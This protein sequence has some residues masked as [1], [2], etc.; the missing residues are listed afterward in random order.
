MNKFQ[1]F[2]IVRL[3]NCNEDFLVVLE[4]DTVLLKYKRLT[5]LNKIF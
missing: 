1:S 5:L 4:S 3:H 2:L